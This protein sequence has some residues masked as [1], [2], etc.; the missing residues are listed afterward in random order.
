[1]GNKIN[2][3]LTGNAGSMG[4]LIDVEKEKY[5]YILVVGAGSYFSN[6]LWG[7]FTEIMVHRFEHWRRGE[8]WND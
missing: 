8:G 3:Y 6:S 2:S 5:K 4:D 7:L 1:M